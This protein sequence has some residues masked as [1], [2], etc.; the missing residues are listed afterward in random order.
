MSDRND[1]V[2]RRLDGRDLASSK[3]PQPQGSGQ[4]APGL[5]P[6]S[7][8][9]CTCG[10]NEPLPVPLIDRRT[11]LKAGASL[12]AG[13]MTGTSFANE[14]NA[15]GCQPSEPQYQTATEDQWVSDALGDR[16]VKAGEFIVYPSKEG[17]GCGIGID[18]SAFGQ[19]EMG[20][21]YTAA[22][23]GVESNP[24]ITG[25]TR[26]DSDWSLLMCRG[27]PW[28]S[29]PAFAELYRGQTIYISYAT[30]EGER[31]C[32]SCGNGQSSS[33]WYRTNGPTGCWFWS[34]GTVHQNWN[35]GNC[36][37]GCW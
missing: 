30:Y 31:I 27:C 12:T 37:R 7:R 5:T 33:Y 29:S 35:Y 14:A 8:P 16:Y 1:D 21:M 6:E 19:D 26:L 10:Q 3:G 2:S 15:Q 18:E 13:L 36:H 20:T 23:C 25:A 28:T 24:P 4:D 22:Q 17:D 9:R 32:E 11:L 34:G